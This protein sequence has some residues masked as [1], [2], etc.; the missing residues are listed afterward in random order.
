MNAYWH[1]LWPFL[2]CCVFIFL[3]NM[4]PKLTLWQMV[5]VPNQRSSHKTIT[6]RGGGLGIIFG[7]LVGTGIAYFLGLPLPGIGFFMGASVV[8]I[9]GF[10]DDR[11]NLPVSIRMV[12]YSFSAICIIYET[13]GLQAFP[14][15]HTQFPLGIWGYFLTYIWIMAIMNIYNFLDGINGYAG[16]QAIIAGITCVILDPV[17]PGMVIGGSIASATLAFL[18]FNWTPAKVFMGDVGSVF[19]GF[20]FSALPFYYHF[21]PSP[22]GVWYMVFMLWFFVS[23][24]VFTILRRLFNGEKVWEAHKSHIFQKLVQHGYSHATVTTVMG[25]GTVALSILLVS[26]IYFKLTY[27]WTPIIALVLFVGFWGWAQFSSKK[28]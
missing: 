28:H 17:G 7:F 11:K 18:W 4:I 21:Q 8:A 12:M 16:T 5:D 19:L 2:F 26:S 24:G 23:D 9:A 15:P 20:V 27:I 6:P 22:M 10:F 13:Q 3:K 14:W 25:I 1:L